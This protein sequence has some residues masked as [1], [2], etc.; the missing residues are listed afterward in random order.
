VKHGRYPTVMAFSLALSSM[1]SAGDLLLSD[2]CDRCQARLAPWFGA[3]RLRSAQISH[4]DD[5]L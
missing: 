1:P 5:V 3:R 2:S 4:W